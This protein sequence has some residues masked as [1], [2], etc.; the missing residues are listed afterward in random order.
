[1]NKQVMCFLIVCNTLGL[2]TIRGSQ[3]L[4][5]LKELIYFIVGLE[6]ITCYIITFLIG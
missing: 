3:K 5:I 6:P 2:V 1:M 4:K